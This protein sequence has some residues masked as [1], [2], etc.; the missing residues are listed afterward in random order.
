MTD[1]T[2]CVCRVGYEPV[3]GTNASEACA[4]CLLGYFKDVA[5]NNPCTPCPVGQFSNA[6]GRSACIFC[7]HVVEELGVIGA[8]TTPE[9]AS[10]TIANC[11]CLPG[12]YRDRGLCAACVPGTYKPDKSFEACR[13]CGAGSAKHRYGKNE[14]EAVN[15]DEH[16]LQCPAYAGNNESLVEEGGLLVDSISKCLCFAG[17]DTWSVSQ[18]EPCGNYTYKIGFSNEDCRSCSPNEYYVD[19]ITPCA[20]CSLPSHNPEGGTHSLA[21]NARDTSQRWGEGEGDCT[22][23]VGYER[24][25]DTCYQ[26]AT[27]HYR[28]TPELDA[29]VR[30]CTRC[31]P[32]TFQNSVQSQE[33][34]QCPANSSFSGTGASS[35]EQCLCH[36][37]YYWLDGACASCPAGTWKKWSADMSR[38]EN[39]A[40]CTPCAP[41]TYSLGTASECT[42]C[43]ANMFSIVG[44]DSFGKCFCNA[45]F[46]VALDPEACEPC[47]NATYW[48]GDAVPRQQCSPCPQSKTSP[49]GSAGEADCRCVPGHGIEPD[50][51]PSAPCLPCTSGS[52]ALGGNQPCESCGWGTVT[53]PPEA[54]AGPE[55]CLCDAGR[56]LLEARVEER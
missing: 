51:P 16:C 1:V 12:H 50:A 29:G 46:G 44:A 55:S 11:T 41:D 17:H 48:R 38:W 10:T 30:F 15:M 37:G 36:D 45:G 31:P 39:L 28:G 27:G 4:P 33:C 32:D 6:T 8:T 13:R 9:S 19:I 14:S 56:G 20:A 49:V 34:I 5:G 22:C 26:C 40:A 21:V 18:C 3:P 35:A 7:A 47:P 54:A 43:A 25:Q 23:R 42:P 24:I 2:A 53:E 52:F